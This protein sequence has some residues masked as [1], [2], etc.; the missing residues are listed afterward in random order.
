MVCTCTVDCTRANDW[1][2][3]SKKKKK[4]KVSSCSNLVPVLLRTH[5]Q[6]YSRINITVDISVIT[7]ANKNTTK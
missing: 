3:V 1:S 2:L 4:D 7:A 6:Q 5:Q